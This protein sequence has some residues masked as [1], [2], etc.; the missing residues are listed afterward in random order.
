[1]SFSVSNNE[2]SMICRYCNKN[3]E[4]YD[5]KL[6]Y[7][8]FNNYH[9]YNSHLRICACRGIDPLNTEPA[10]KRNWVVYGANGYI[11]NVN[12]YTESMMT[13]SAE[14]SEDHRYRYKLSRIWEPTQNK[15]LFIML[16]PSTADSDDDDMTIK[17]LLKITKKWSEK[18]E[19][20]GGFHVGNLYPY[21]SSKPSELLG[22]PIPEHI[23]EKNMKSIE[24]MMAECNRV[25]YAWGTKGPIQNQMPP[26]WLTNMVGNDAHCI[27]I[28]KNG[29]P[30][31]PKQWG[32]NVRPVPDEPTPFIS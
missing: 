19:N 17:S 11:V 8:T 22:H 1:M 2:A 16:N 12:P 18:H 6:I 24:E 14:F 4:S 21:C 7:T 5:L 23:H 27:W 13:R 15:I 10:A 30:M 20:Y 28:S 9:G 32:P 29:V 26:E 31:H 3:V 25:V